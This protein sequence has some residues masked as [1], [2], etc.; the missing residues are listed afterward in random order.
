MYELVELGYPRTQNVV[1]GW[2]NRWN[3]LVGNAHVS[4]YK[5]IEEMRKE[6]QQME[7]QVE[8]IIRGE[9]RPAQRK[10]YVDHVEFGTGCTNSVLDPTLIGFLT[11]R[12]VIS[13]QTK[14]GLHLKRV[15]LGAGPDLKHNRVLD[16]NFIFQLLFRAFS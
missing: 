4:I 1:E 3:T 12:V 6:Q 14:T 11:N 7:M 5:I 8:S 9:S 15:Q 2:H 13:G 16:P 10:K